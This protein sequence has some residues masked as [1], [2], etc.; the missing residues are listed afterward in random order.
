VGYAAPGPL[1]AWTAG[2][3]LSCTI[4]CQNVL[5]YEGGGEEKH[6]VAA[7]AAKKISSA[8]TVPKMEHK[9]WPPCIKKRTRPL[10]GNW[11]GLPCGKTYLMRVGMPR[12][13]N[14][15]VV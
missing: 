5:P 15:V 14:Y 13:Y 3:A 9:K 6:D 7:A 4:R 1:P 10:Y 11:G 2:N 8:D 12:A